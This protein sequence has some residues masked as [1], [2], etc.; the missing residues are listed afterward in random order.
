LLRTLVGLPELFLE[1]IR[2]NGNTL[3]VFVH[4]IYV[5]PAQGLAELDRSQTVETGL[6]ARLRA[7][8]AAR[9]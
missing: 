6:L 4:I 5:I 7:V 8:H 1:S 2:L 3:E 9:S